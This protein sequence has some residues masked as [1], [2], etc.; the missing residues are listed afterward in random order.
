MKTI[1]D[2]CLWKGEFDLNTPRVDGEMFKSGEKKLQIKKI[3][4]YLWTVSTGPMLHGDVHKKI[5]I[6]GF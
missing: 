3:S 2:G 4:R 5:I 1:G 6:T